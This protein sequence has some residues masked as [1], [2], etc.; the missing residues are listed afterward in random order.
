MSI[1][2][3]ATDRYMDEPDCLDG[4]HMTEVV[5]YMVVERGWWGN[6][7]VSSIDTQTTAVA[8]WHRVAYLGAL[9]GEVVVFSQVQV[10]L[11][12]SDCG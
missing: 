5:S 2:P 4:T 12:Q 3:T 8:S 9:E 10:I 7:Q 6:I 1:E 11:P